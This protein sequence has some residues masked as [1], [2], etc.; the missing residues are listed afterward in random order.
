MSW[1]VQ[2]LLIDS[3]TLKEN[4]DFE[5]E[6]YNDLL[7]LEK[8]I[9]TLAKQGL[10]SPLELKALSLLAEGYILEDIEKFLAMSGPTVSKLINESCNRI[11][12]YLGGSFTDEGLISEMRDKYKL[13]NESIEKL[14]QYIYSKYR[15]KI[16][17][18]Q[19]K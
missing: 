5:S 19:T 17:R 9:D 16:M 1:K 12:Y 13:D 15:H 4:P 3:L 6:D 7:I 11:A 18:S 8:K 14:I 2:R 10:L